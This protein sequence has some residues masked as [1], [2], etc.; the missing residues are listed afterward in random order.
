MR[1][2]ISASSVQQ[3]LYESAPLHA[4]DRKKSQTVV[5]SIAVNIKQQSS[6][7][8]LEVLALGVVVRQLRVAATRA[9]HC[10]C[11]CNHCLKV[12]TAH[13]VYS[14]LVTLLCKTIVQCKRF[15]T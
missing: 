9:W 14:G 10:S 6:T 11:V 3:P 15:S 13:I 1:Y 5:V 2:N 4:C 12:S 8:E 7:F